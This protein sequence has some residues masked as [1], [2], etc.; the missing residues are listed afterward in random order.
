MNSQSRKVILIRVEIETEAER[1]AISEA[2]E[3]AK[4]RIVGNDS[5]LRFANV[6]CLF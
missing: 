5:L 4:Q 6:D 3:G 1:S 2:V